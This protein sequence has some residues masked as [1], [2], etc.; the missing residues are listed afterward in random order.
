MIADADTTFGS[1]EIAGNASVN[2]S[3]SGT[4]IFSFFSQLK[5]IVSILDE[6]DNG[7]SKKRFRF[8]DRVDTMLLQQV[9]GCHVFEAEFGEMQKKWEDVANSFKVCNIRMS[10]ICARDRTKLLLK[11]FSKKDRG[12]RLASGVEE[13]ISEKD[14]LLQE[15]LSLKQTR[16]V[17]KEKEKFSCAAVQS[18]RAEM[19]KLIMQ[20]ATSRLGT[21]G[22]LA[23]ETSEESS[24]RTPSPSGLSLSGTKRQRTDLASVLDESS[25]QRAAIT[26]HI[27]QQA[28]SLLP[29]FFLYFTSFLG[30][31]V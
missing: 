21:P 14:K 16:T 13:E 17:E 1:A 3:T 11:D 20:A 25:K 23:S 4:F 29:H 26:A 6:E 15:I 27:L 7:E 19:G 9:I 12:K 31:N 24:Y 22:K 8:N 10:W 18:Q 28:L 2:R 30:R 5:L